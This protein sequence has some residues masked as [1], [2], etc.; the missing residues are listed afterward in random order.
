MNTI[1]DKE[2]IQ[3]VVNLDQLYLGLESY[4]DLSEMPGSV[5]TSILVNTQ[6]AHCK[7]QKKSVNDAFINMPFFR[8][9]ALARVDG[10]DDHLWNPTLE[11][12]K[13]FS[14]RHTGKEVIYFEDENFKSTVQFFQKQFEPLMFNT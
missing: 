14:L 11:S 4:L 3:F 7:F 13:E 9:S 8:I 5:I 10:K 1:E 12:L 2:V 6:D